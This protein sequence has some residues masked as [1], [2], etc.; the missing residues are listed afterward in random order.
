TQSRRPLARPLR[1]PAATPVTA[2]KQRGQ[3]RPLTNSPLIH[4]K[5]TQQWHR[6]SRLQ[7]GLLPA[8]TAKRRTTPARPKKPV[9]AAA[10]QQKDIPRNRWYALLLPSNAGEALAK[11]LRILVSPATRA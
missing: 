3:P 7:N 1:K 6:G 5:P 4:A 9:R 11:D 2:P 8:T 10:S